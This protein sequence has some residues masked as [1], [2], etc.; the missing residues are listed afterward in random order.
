MFIAFVIP[1]K[2]KRLKKSDTKLREKILFTYGVST[3]TIFAERKKYPKNR[4][5]H[6]HTTYY[7][8]FRSIFKSNNSVFLKDLFTLMNHLFK[9]NQGLFSILQV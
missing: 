4:D 6:W 7:N 2:A 5:R 9:K 1:T 3:L 8:P